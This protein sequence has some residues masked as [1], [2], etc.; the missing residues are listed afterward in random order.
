[1]YCVFSNTRIP[2]DA[3]GLKKHNT[4]PLAFAQNL[5]LAVGVDAHIDPQITHKLTLIRERPMCRSAKLA[6]RLGNVYLIL[7]RSDS[8]AVAL[9]SLAQNKIH[10]PSPYMNINERMTKMSLMIPENYK[11]DLTIRQTE[12]AIKK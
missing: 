11:S 8:S 12:V 6:L 5:R 1:M 9:N 7:A 10:I 4:H 2:A 3:I